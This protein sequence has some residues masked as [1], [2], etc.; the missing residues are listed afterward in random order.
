MASSFQL[1]LCSIQRL[2]GVVGWQSTPALQLR[3]ELYRGI[4][5]LLGLLQLASLAFPG[6]SASE[7]AERKRE[8]HPRSRLA[9]N[10]ISGSPRNAL[11]STPGSFS[12][13]VAIASA[14]I[15]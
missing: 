7:E 5:G 8:D 10:D 15:R 2:S 1:L 14:A 6:A 11:R 3:G 13:E 4:P 9:Q 12:Q